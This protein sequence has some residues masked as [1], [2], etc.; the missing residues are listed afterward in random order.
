MDPPNITTTEGRG[1]RHNPP[2][3][4]PK[5]VELDKS[6]AGSN[7]A[8]VDGPGTADCFTNLYNQGD[9][10]EKGTTDEMD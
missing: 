9:V 10:N 1:K 4:L 8:V 6:T 5:S 7:E 2:S 3:S